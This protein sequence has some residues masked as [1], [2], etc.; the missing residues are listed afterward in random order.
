MLKKVSPYLVGIFLLGLFIPAS[1]AENSKKLGV[2][3]K[4]L[5]IQNGNYEEICS[6]LEK[7]IQASEFQL[8]GKWDLDTANPYDYLARVYVLNYPSFTQEVAR[9]EG[10]RFLSVA[11]R[12]CVYQ[13]PAQKTILVNMVNPETIA[14]VYFYKLPD[15]RYQKMVALATEVKDKM[16]QLIKNNLNGT[17]VDQQMPPIREVKALNGYNGDGMAKV[18]ALFKDYKGSL[19]KVKEY[20]VANDGSRVFQK[21]CN[22]LEANLAKT[23]TGWKLIG[24]I[25]GGNQRRYFGISQPYTEEL[26]TR[27]VGEKRKNKD[28]LAPGIDHSP[29]FPIEILVYGEKDK[30]KVATLGEMWRMQFYFWDA[31]YAAFAKHAQIPSQIY[32][33]IVNVI[34][35]KK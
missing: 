15:D 33:S 31:G 10:P 25:D 24:T 19:H 29:A 22:E 23:K 17:F 13:G 26:A 35:G 20:K 21:A 27:I 11:H 4:V 3:I 6:H 16:I 18:M 32:N 5:E 1:H 2:Y 7:G 8:V 34:K 28:N 14:H 9:L 12:I 30:I